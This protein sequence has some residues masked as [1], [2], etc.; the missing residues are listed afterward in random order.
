MKLKPL[1]VIVAVLAAVSLLVYFLQRPAPTADADP[2][3]GQPLLDSARVEEAGRL[4]LTENDRTV[5]LQQ[6]D[7]EWRVASFHD[8]PADFGK[9]SRFVNDLTDSRLER[10]VTRNPDTMAR[11]QFGNTSIALAR[12]DGTA[13]WTVEL[14]RTTDGGGRFVRF[15]QGDR[16]YLARLAAWLDTTPRNW[17]DSRLVVLTADQVAR[18]ELSWPEQDR[19]LALARSSTQQP[20]AADNGPG[21]ALRQA[22]VTTLLGTLAQLR[23]SD[24]QP[25]EQ[26]EDLEAA[27]A[28]SRVA[29]LTT[30]SGESVTIRLGRRP[31]PA[32]PDGEATEGETETPDLAEPAGPVR[33]WIEG[34]RELAPLTGAGEALIFQVSDYPWTT[35]PAD[36]ASLFEEQAPSPNATLPTDN[37]ADD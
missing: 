30:F 25:R 2:R 22:P 33:A 20:F 10:L 8:L 26:V 12:P 13:L 36:P 4:S 28:H 17:V 6:V 19:S 18:V 1:L 14:G 31:A 5:T 15:G 21:G 3:V 24:T 27:L 16:A 37:P 7:G 9:L 34:P 29:R 11:L 35:W 32:S 23:F